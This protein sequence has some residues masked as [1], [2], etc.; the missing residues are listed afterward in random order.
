MESLDGRS[1]DLAVLKG[2]IRRHFRV[3]TGLNLGLSGWLQRLFSPFQEGKR[4]AR[5]K[6]KGPHVA[7]AIGFVQTGIR[8]SLISLQFSAFIG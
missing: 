7:G 8:R 2:N 3:Q 5:S 4:E 1:D 6:Q